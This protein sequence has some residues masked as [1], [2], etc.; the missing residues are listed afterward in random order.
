MISKLIVIISGTVERLQ[1]KVGPLPHFFCSFKTLK[2]LYMKGKVIS[3]G[4]Y[5]KSVHYYYRIDRLS[6]LN[7]KV[8]LI[9]NQ[10]SLK[11]YLCCDIG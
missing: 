1:S 11:D 7:L 8:S 9:S 3:R 4:A 6:T 10:L 5:N 2:F